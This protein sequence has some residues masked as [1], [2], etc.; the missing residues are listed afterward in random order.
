MMHFL[1][2]VL[3][4]SEVWALVIPIIVLIVRKKQPSYFRP[5]IIY[6]WLALIVDIF[7]DIGSNYAGPV[8]HWLQP[9]TYLYNIHSVIRF[10]CFSKFFIL[11][12]QPSLIFIKKLIPFLSLGFVIIN[13]VFFEDF[14]YYN[15]FS[16]RL[17]AIEAGLLLFYCLQYYLYSL[18]TESVKTYKQRDFWLVTGLSI[19][20]V[21]NFPYF[22]L[23]K[24]LI[25]NHRTFVQDMWNY[26][27]VTF[28]ILCIF[29]ARA[30]YTSPQG[31]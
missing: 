23:Y 20:V 19:Y 22:L 26:H 15:S 30:F 4:W 24:S 29:I 11:L 2:T 21:F 16:S 7:I 8:P 5:I 3:D 31:N 27:N 9:N 1:I 18:H 6:I 13:F 28:I 14:F 25:P 12:K 17:F 10:I